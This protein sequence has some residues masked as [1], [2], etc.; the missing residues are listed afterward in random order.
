[1]LPPPSVVTNKKCGATRQGAHF[2]NAHG[3]DGWTPSPP[4]EGGE[5]R[6]EEGRRPQNL[7]LS[8]AHSPL[9]PRE[10][11]EKLGVPTWAPRRA[12][13][14]FALALL[15]TGCGPP[16]PRALLDG[17][18]L[19]KQGRYPAAVERL[20]KATELL[21]TDARAWNYFG[22][23][24][25]GNQQPDD[26]L[27]A[28]KTALDLDHNLAA[29]RYNLGCLH[30]EQNHLTNAVHELTSFAL[31][32]PANVDGWLQLAAAHLRNRS[33][34]EAER[35]YKATLALQPRHPEALNG[36]GMIQFQRRNWKDAANNFSLALAQN[37]KFGP[38]LLNLA[39]VNQQGLNNRPA[40][41]K[42]YN[43]YLASQPRNAEWRNVEIL[44]RQLDA[45]LNPPPL[46][47]QPAT[48]PVPTHAAIPA[49]P[50]V[51]PITN[52]SP[53]HPAPQPQL[54]RTNPA[55]PVIPTVVLPPTIP[56]PVTNPVLVAVR[57]SSPTEV[58]RIPAN[59]AFRPVEIPATAVTSDLVIKP[60]QDLSAQPAAP[61]VPAPLNNSS[62]TLPNIPIVSPSDSRVNP[63]PAKRSFI[64]RLNPFSRNPK[65]QELKKA[66]PVKTNVMVASATPVPVTPSPPPPPPP[67]VFPRYPF[68]SPAAPLAGNRAQAD[69][70]FA[71]GLRAHQAGNRKQAIDEYQNALRADPAYF[72][73]YYNLGLA[74]QDTGE[75][76]LALIAFE[77]AL[78]LKPDSLEARYN[79]AIALK[80]G[81]YA[82]DA[83]EQLNKILRSNPSEIRAH[84]SM[85]NI[86]AQQMRQPADARA[87]YE[88]VLQLNPNHS[89][90]AKIRLWLGNN[91]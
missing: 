83:L 46:V 16:G 75:L 76:G 13:I 51:R 30:L 40:A 39:V 35:C 25:Q 12:R 42:A 66:P 15:L 62:P 71:R 64:S 21:P 49:P 5:G 29:A 60:A 28:Y 88:K 47:I 43:A 34:N 68:Q 7:P 70:A 8:P 2:E 84:L 18:K 26:A 77:T 37:P 73:A 22:L 38:A 41:L 74:A 19:I 65:E 81:G 53:V 87:H 89:E 31:L 67:P 69:I 57:P 48:P 27:R 58:P 78:A 32:Q 44:A 3:S 63:D 52:P 56:P 14:A 91:P 17:E 24:L 55:V 72:D 50:V 1:M 36:L 79:F 85:A 82:P 20:K 90:A 45:E 23:A 9:V 11:R 6:G 59:P 33:L 10:E 54:A 61:P 4:A 80:T 86:Y